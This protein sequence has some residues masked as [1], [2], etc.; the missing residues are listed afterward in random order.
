MLCAPIV[1]QTIHLRGLLLFAPLD[2]QIPVLHTLACCSQT[3][4]V[5]PA[6]KEEQKER[7]TDIHKGEEND[8]P[9]K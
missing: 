8:P 7:E 1:Q 6:D 4:L 5:A 2:S 9:S 3:D